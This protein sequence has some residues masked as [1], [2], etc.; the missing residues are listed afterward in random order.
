MLSLRGV[1]GPT[2]H[3]SNENPLLFSLALVEVMI[4]TEE[5][6]SNYS[7]SLNFVKSYKIYRLLVLK[8]V[9]IYLGLAQWVSKKEDIEPSADVFSNINQIKMKI[10]K[11]NRIRGVDQNTIIYHAM[12]G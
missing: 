8:G 7:M 12:Q 4:T 5:C 3:C 6:I 9:L 1:L 2:H 10:R 11:N